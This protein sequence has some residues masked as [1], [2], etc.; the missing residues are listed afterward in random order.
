MAVFLSD[1]LIGRNG[2][3]LKWGDVYTKLNRKHV[4]F[5]NIMHAAKFLLKSTAT[6]T[7]AVMSKELA[8]CMHISKSSNSSNCSQKIP[9]FN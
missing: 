2:S 8:A 3:N 1:C 4:F 5:F 9:P 7:F 6:L